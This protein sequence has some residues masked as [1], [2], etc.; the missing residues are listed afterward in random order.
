M[1][2]LPD[3]NLLDGKVQLWSLPVFE[4][5]PGAGAPRLKRLKL[6]Q[7]E[8]AQLY[9]GQPGIQYLAFI[10]LR[11]HTVRGNHFH[12]V[13]QEFV[14]LIS[15]QVLLVVEDVD[16]KARASSTLKPGDKAFI[17][18]RV[19]H[20][21]YVLEPGQAIEFSPTAFEAADAQRYI[22]AAP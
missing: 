17:S 6:A 8:L 5:P 1:L 18:T 3:S 4:G 20:A 15:G 21:L 12:E 13:K 11:A 22:V 14:Y 7:G 19:A 2:P 9:D 10:E 16:S